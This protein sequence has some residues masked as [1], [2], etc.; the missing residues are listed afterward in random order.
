M[1]T[2]IDITPIPLKSYEIENIS[3]TVQLTPKYRH[4]FL[5]L[6]NYLNYVTLKCMHIPFYF[7]LEC[8]GDTWGPTSCVNDCPVCYNGGICDDVLGH[9]I[10]APGFSGTNCQIRKYG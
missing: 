10:C 7:Y 2:F 6:G 1:Y 8:D 5:N 4:N 9:C 3:Q